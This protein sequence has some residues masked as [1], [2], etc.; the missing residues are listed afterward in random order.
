MNLSADWRLP[1]SNETLGN[2]TPGKHWA[3]FFKPADHSHMTMSGKFGR[4]VLSA[5]VLTMIVKTVW[6]ENDSFA[7]GRFR[8]GGDG[9]IQLVAEK[10]GRSFAGRYRRKSGLYSE[11]AYR[12]L[13]RVFG[14]PYSPQRTG[15]SLR[16]IEF[17]DFLQDRFGQN[18]NL[19]ITSGYRSPAYN[20]DLR[21]RGALAAKASLH[22]YGMAADLK[23]PGVS[24]RRIWD[25]VKG[26]GFGGA[27]YYHGDTV[28]IDVGP[29]RS[30]D[31][32][33]SGVGTGISDDNKLIGLITDYDK[34]LPGDRVLIRFIR[35][36]AFPIGVDPEFELISLTAADAGIE[37]VTF[38][39][40]FRAPAAKGC[41]QFADIEQMA[42][43]EWRLPD[44]VSAG[45]YAIQA[46]F[47]GRTGSAMPTTVS[48]PEIEIVTP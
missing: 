25:Y 22:Q 43:I 6:A 20:T 21:N 38:R 48:T 23:M 9:R 8:Y 26:L 45:P 16:L 5:L 39:P 40:A 19:I 28:H 29:A 15:L 33:S 27:G 37:K 12:A 1:E 14:A 2:R 10:T 3:A 34:Y 47:C 31:E 7:D 30:W 36:T 13:C 35:M 17:L 18:S 46:G 24:S 32:K 11:Q 4:T 41:P 42:A 44:N